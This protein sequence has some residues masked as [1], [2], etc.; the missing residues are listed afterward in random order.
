M[1]DQEIVVTLA[2]GGTVRVTRDQVVVQPGNPALPP[3]VTDLRIV[4]DVRRVADYVLITRVRRRTMQITLTSEADAE[5]LEEGIRATL[6]RAPRMSAVRSGTVSRDTLWLPLGML[7]CA[8]LI[9]VGSLGPWAEATIVTVNGTDWDG[10]LTIM[11]GIVAGASSGLLLRQPWRRGWTLKLIT[12]AFA[13]AALVGLVDWVDVGR[14]ID[15]TGLNVRA[16][17]GLMLM[18]VAGAIGVAL[19]IAQYLR[20]PQHTGYVAEATLLDER[21]GEGEGR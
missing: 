6:K 14:V 10:D 19:A 15:E 12:I 20:R 13:L 5:R 11:F 21:L 9:V 8:A 3:D 4:K 7:A 16:G 18:T 2:S 1:E 17:W